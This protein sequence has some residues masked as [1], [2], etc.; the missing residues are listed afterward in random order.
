MLTFG[1][2]MHLMNGGNFGSMIYKSIV[3]LSE[4]AKTIKELDDILDLFVLQVAKKKVLFTLQPSKNISIFLP[5]IVVCL[6][7]FFLILFLLFH[8]AT[9]NF[10]VMF[11]CYCL[12]Y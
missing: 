12:Y 4:N 7:I 1:P 6:L 5:Y 11:F 9:S 8:L 10:I 2:R 3:D